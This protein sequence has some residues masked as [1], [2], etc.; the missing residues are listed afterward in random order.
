M[1]FDALETH[2]TDTGMRTQHGNT[3]HLHIVGTVVSHKEKLCM[4]AIAHSNTQKQTTLT[5]CILM[6]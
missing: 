5:V 3:I 1:H 2:M 4:S 6:H